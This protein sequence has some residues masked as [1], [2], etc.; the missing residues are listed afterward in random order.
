MAAVKERKSFFENIVFNI[1]NGDRV[2]WM[3]TILLMMFSLV[4]IFSSTSSKA[5]LEHTTRTAIFLGQLKI[6]GAGV[7]VILC[8]CAFS[9]LR[10]F[11]KISRWGYL[12]SLGLLCLMLVMQATG[13]PI[14]PMKVISANGVVR[15]IKIGG[16]SLQVYEVVKVAMVMYLS[17]ALQTYESNA[18]STTN[19]LGTRF[20]TVFGWMK[21][22]AAQ[23]WLY[24]FIPVLII[25]LLILKGSTGS[26]LLVMTVSL[27]TLLIGGMKWKDLLVAGGIAL[28]CFAFVILL[29]VVSSGKVM[30]RLQTAANR[31]EIELPYPDTQ[32]REAQR[33]AIQKKARNLDE[34]ELRSEDF[35]K[36]IDLHRQPEAAE[37]AMVEGGRK[38]LGKGPGKSTQKY[39][40]PVMF[41]DYMFDFIVEEYGLLISM[42][43]MMLY[44]SLFARG[45]IIVHHCS[46]R[47]AK[48]CVGGLV[49][50]I[51]GQALLHIIVNLNVGL[52][53]GQTLP[54]I[55]HG[56]CSLLCFS[57]ALG[58]ILSISTMANKKVM[59]A[60]EA[61][62]KLLES[63]DDISTGLSIMEGI[64]DQFEQLEQLEQLEN[65]DKRNESEE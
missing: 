13:K 40:V 8:C 7:L 36:Y 5:I 18:F 37:I 9:N 61:E 26:A 42:F 46:N 54:M 44:I 23:R 38:I 21:N 12:F 49:F 1:K 33:K 19:K 25:P 30:S 15:A 55:S 35:F 50:L 53:T 16:F 41:E 63:T 29:H 2:V 47:Y 62:Q 65:L 10:A 51:T 43:V 52:L 27:V 6:V 34:I 57:F 39:I 24:I 14:G 58:V 56:R 28:G 11:R 20:P 45:V 3:L 48:A 31:L 22:A 32:A 60:S 59:K 17:W 4:A 64:D